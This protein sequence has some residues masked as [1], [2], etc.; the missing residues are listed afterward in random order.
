M[1]YFNI[2]DKPNKEK[3]NEEFNWY[4]TIR[5][6]MIFLHGGKLTFRYKEDEYLVKMGAAERQ[7]RGIKS[8]Y[9]MLPEIEDLEVNNYFDMIKTTNQKE[10][11]NWFHNSSY[12]DD[13]SIGDISNEGIIF[14]VPDD[15]KEDFC[16]NL[17]GQGFRYE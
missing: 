4:D 10:I 15:D 17:E 14:E 2:K 3:I 11:E 9:R 8:T 16:D 5:K 13:I 6:K 12:G 7:R 1:I